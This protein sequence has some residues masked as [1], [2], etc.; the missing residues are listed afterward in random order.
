MLGLNRLGFTDENITQL[1]N[2]SW[3]ETQK[4]I[5]AISGKIFEDSKKGIKSLL[6]AYYA[7]H[8]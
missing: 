8:G 5:M 4:A 1:N 2:P 6:F 7:G 3:D